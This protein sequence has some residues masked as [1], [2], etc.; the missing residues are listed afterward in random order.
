[1][2]FEIGLFCAPSI[3]SSPL[4]SIVCLGAEMAATKSDGEQS[5][6]LKKLVGVNSS[7]GRFVLCPELVILPP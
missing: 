2:E 4:W 6:K 1:M 7:R 3:L 5:H